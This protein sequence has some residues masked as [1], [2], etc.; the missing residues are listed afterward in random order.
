MKTIYN[1][2]VPQNSILLTEKFYG[3]SALNNIGGTSH[4]YEPLDFALYKKAINNF[5]KNNDSFRIRLEQK[6]DLIKQYISDYCEFEIEIIDVTKDEDVENLEKVQIS[7]PFNIFNEPLF[8]FKIF[9]FKDNTGGYVLRAHH[10][11]T[12]AWGTG[13]LCR[14]IMHEYSNLLNNINETPDSRL[15][16]VQYLESE[17]S[18]LSSPKFEKD[19]AYW[20]EKF[21]TAPNMVSIPYSKNSNNSFSCL[22]NRQTF[23]FSKHEKD[24]IFNFCQQN[25]ISVFNFFM[26]IIS[27]YLYKINN[28]DDFVLGTPILNRSNVVE[29]NT[30]GMFINIM[31]LRVS[32]SNIITF[33]DLIQKISKDSMGLLRHQKYPYQNILQAV[34][35][36]DSSIPN[37][38]N[39][40]LSYQITKANN[41]SEF[42]YT[43]RWAF[44]GC[45]A[46]DIDI[47]I[48]DLDEE[49]ILNISY[50]YKIS[51]YLDEDIQKLHNR[52]LN[53]IKQ[54]IKK[55]EI[56]I[57]DLDII[58]PEEA[59]HILNDFNNTVVK[60]DKEKTLF[61]LFENQV[62]KTPDN[63]AVIDKNK[64]LTYAELNSR[65]NFVANEINKLNI[66]T[67]IIAFSL[68]RTSNIIVTILGILK[69]G[70]TYMPI[71]P[72]YP[73]E[74][75]NY[76]LE[77]SNTKLV[78]STEKFLENIKYNE[79]FIDFDKLPFD[80]KYSNPN[81]KVSSQKN[82]Y[83]MYT[84]G[85]TGLPKAVAIKH[86]NVHN[87]VKS[88]QKIMDYKPSKNNV[89]LSVT[90]V[91]FDIFVSEVFPTLLS[92]LTLVIADELEARSPD[93][94]SKI[95]EKY[96]ISKIWTTPSR[97]ELL[98]M[99]K[100]YT[101]CLS[102]VKEFS[103]GGE[104]VP[105]QLVEKMRKYTSAKIF[106]FY[107]PTETT[108]YSTYKDI[109]SSEEISIGKPINNTQVYI[110]NENNKLLPINQVGEICIGGDGVGNGYYTSPEKTKEV[111]IKNPYG[112]GFI[113]KTGDLGYFM[114]N[115]ELIC[116]GR[117]DFQVKI[118]G[119]RIEL[120]D[121]SNNV[122]SYDGIEKC[123]VIDK[124]DEDGNQYLCAYFI[125]TNGKKIDINELRKYL[126]NLLPNYMIP[127]YFMQLDSFPLT[128]NHKIDR[129]AFPTPDIESNNT[130]INY[131]PPTTDTQ[132]KLCE[133]IQ[134]SL[135]IAKIGIK[136]DLFN[137]NL[138]SLEI[139]KIQTKMLS[140]NF[141]VNTQDFYNL[142]T[143]EKIAEL[144]DNNN[145]HS[146][147]ENKIDAKLLSTI[148]NSF[149]KHVDIDSTLFEKKSYNNVLLIGCTGYLGM[150][151]LHSLINQTK[152]HIY[153]LARD[154]N[155]S[156]S[157]NRINEL[158]NFYFKKDIALDRV[159]II[160]SDIT[161]ENLGLSN[162][163]YSLLLDNVDLVINAA[164]N[165]RYYGNYESFKKI[166]ID[167]V[168]NLIDLC[169]A[170]HSKF[171]HIS[172]T[173]ICGNILT[174]SKFAS[175]FSEN[176]FYIGQNYTDN[177][178]IRT[179]FEAEKMI[180]EYAKKDLNA[181]IFR[182]GNLTGRHS[183]GLFQQNIEDNSFY[184]ILR[185]IL[186]FKIIPESMLNE[187]LEFTPIDEC[188]N[189]IIRLVSNIETNNYVFHIFNNNYLPVRNL[190][191][192]LSE[193]NYNVEI[194]SGIDFK[195]K[196]LSFAEDNP[197]DNILK[198]IVNNLDDNEGL[199]LH[200]EITQSNIFTNAYL[201]E[202]NFNWPKV[203]SQYLAKII[204]Y[205]KKNNYING[206]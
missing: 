80:K 165:V 112:S 158:Y 63:I 187:Y 129:K 184:N 127:K 36:M 159:T 51:K 197:K 82:A 43:T 145:E 178:Y 30:N 152:S 94:L 175:T 191:T 26:S 15:S 52:L 118:R 53:L 88:V 201:N 91:C 11:I 107:G 65:A 64:K 181:S 79:T 66:K 161:K 41:E 48:Y 71:D 25:N 170:N 57:D 92:G 10:S 171:I 16:Y 150:H 206:D 195:N 160:S 144:I 138:D 140:Y 111:F 198:N 18:Y 149:K 60:Y 193:I 131:E 47:H 120:N 122:I 137:F 59:Q 155:N 194:L 132:K 54:V 135:K 141:K 115:G 35:K 136:N 114:P 105:I 174:S 1:L 146:Y 180:Y 73:I 196:I 189:A 143:I 199:K 172:T 124:K 85:S 32:F 116:L 49:G 45:C 61:E 139:I 125:A 166:N 87:Y 157:I 14:K 23:T 86:C 8:E 126:I 96:K 29:K 13:L 176:D 33:N 98:F 50:D 81:I 190:L 204:N 156:N 188:A 185:M 84:S 5:V 7:K 154:K 100:N 186:Q 56:N 38:Y 205:I 17:K 106:D 153:C 182:V 110:L 102:I 24:I 200:S 89:V 179:K 169:M 77:N 31:P 162:K 108:V 2:S 19:K 133:I 104:P 78:I 147:E 90:T 167:V 164:A 44:N 113:Y 97:I 151:L 93:L 72:D 109:T 203:D 70:H 99:D 55:P 12:D 173:G 142:R 183:D 67:D 202:L 128:V 6:N 34:R 28:I 123:V 62:K 20:E 121:I 101:N 103:L 95:I 3:N 68:E 42:N 117:K 40:L 74:R 22:A 130:L 134:N 27:T 168:K 37:L 21:F 58:T 83:I 39:V 119:Y 46:D 4:V 9:R 69:S 192:Y 76:M 148:N 177:V 163:N 75:I